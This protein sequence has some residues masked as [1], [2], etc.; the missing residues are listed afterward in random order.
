MKLWFLGGATAVIEQNGR[1]MLFDPWLV[2]GI[3]HGSWYHYPPS[4]VSV[5]ELGRLDYVY[6][7]H[8][9]ED[10]C[11]ANTIEHLDFNAE[12]VLLDRKPNFVLQFL[13]QHNFRF[14]REHLIP[15][16]TPTR[17]ADDMVV[18]MLPGDES[19]ELSYLIDSVM[20]LRWGDFT[21][22]NANDCQLSE[23]VLSYIQSAYPAIDLALLPFSGGS[24]YP[25]C[26]LN[27]TTEDKVRER[28]RIIAMRARTFAEFARRLRP[29]HIMPFAD[30]YV[31]A[32]SRAHLN[33]YI[34]HTASPPLLLE[35][36]I[37]E[38]GLADRLL[39]LNAGQTFDF[40][41]GTRTPDEPFRRYTEEDREAYIAAHLRGVKYD[42]EA[43]AIDPRVS[44]ERLARVARERLWL[45]QQK[46]SLF[47]PV[48]LCLDVPDRNARYRI[49]LDRNEVESGTMDDPPAEPYLRVV[50]NSTLMTLLLIGH[51]S[52]NIADAALFLDYE[53][54]PNTYD[55]AVYVLLNLLKV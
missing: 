12:V 25:S 31:I 54:R 41:T 40:K 39:L 14:R 30:Q 18:D 37:A 44:I 29:R 1:R 23:S 17:I 16:R 43:L 38:A 27:L 20:V 10:H 34:S 6:I 15:E 46:R 28:E 42:Y 52:W 50:A 21:L 53:R 33:R 35:Q 24:G 32:G 7:S 11:A 5:H 48:T 9:H 2:D 55:P 49:P 36:L 45:D 8:I 13:R 51:V 4:P 22:V 47:R 19:N 26:Y 3:F